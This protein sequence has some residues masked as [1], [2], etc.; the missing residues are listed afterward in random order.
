MYH[1][2]NEK[3]PSTVTS[4]LI[5]TALNLKRIIPQSTK[6]TQCEMTTDKS[7]DFTDMGF[8]AIRCVFQDSGYS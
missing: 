2:C 7:F 8:T 5:K 1:I 4:F 6:R 3:C